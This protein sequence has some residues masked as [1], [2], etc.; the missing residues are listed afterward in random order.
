MSDL[1]LK[2]NEGFPDNGL[3]VISHCLFGG[4]FTTKLGISECQAKASGCESGGVRKRIWEFIKHIPTDQFEHVFL[5]VKGV[6]TD[7]EFGRLKQKICAESD[8]KL[9]QVCS[10]HETTGC[11]KAEA[12]KY[13]GAACDI[14]D[15]GE[16]A[17]FTFGSK[18]VD[19]NDLRIGGKPNYQ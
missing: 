18:V 12:E 14:I 16:K 19:L 15:K 3:Y 10:S 8:G 2:N 4:V 5:M 11:N 9:L 13:F 6:Y 1:D 17:E 7:K